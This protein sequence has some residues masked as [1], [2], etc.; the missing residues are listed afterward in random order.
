MQPCPVSC[1]RPALT[2]FKSTDTVVSAAA[3]GPFVN[4]RYNK[5][6]VVSHVLKEVHTR[7]T[8][9][10]FTNEGAGKRIVVEYSSPNIA[11][12]FHAGHLRST[13][14]GN[15]IANIYQ[16][17]GFDVTRI[18]YLGDWG[19]QY[20]AAHACKHGSGAQRRLLTSG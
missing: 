5:A 9:Y 10:G 8:A 1:P 19:K 13:I 12:P 18:N 16:G 14:I 17:N 20:G 11:K 3:T 7:G 6:A 15:F 4:F 2:Q